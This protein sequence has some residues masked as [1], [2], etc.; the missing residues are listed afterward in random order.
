M[1]VVDLDGKIVEG[2]FK[3][4]SDLIA[5]LYIYRCRPDVGGVV[6]TH[7]TFATAFSAV[8]M[9]LLPYLLTMCDEFG[10]PVPCTDFA[11]ASEEIGRA[12]V[13]A[14]GNSS[15]VLLKQHGVFTIGSSPE[16]ALRAAV[17]VEDLARKTYFALQLGQPEV[18][19]PEKVDQARRL[20]LEKY[21]QRP[22]LQN[23]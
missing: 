10:G 20:F 6:H 5:H 9:P 14:I 22:E 1:V 19:P 16:E 15:A 13:N 11:I 3:P 7:S 23:H 4:S 18:I 21:S 2:S 8:G 17:M 12:V